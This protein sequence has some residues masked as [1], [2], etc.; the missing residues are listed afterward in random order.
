MV[1]IIKYVGTYRVLAPLDYLTNKVTSNK[2]DTYLLGRY[3]IQAYRWNKNTICLLFPSGNST[4]NIILPQFDEAGIKYTLHI[5]SDKEKIYKVKES[6]IDKIHNI[7][8]FQIKGKG[9]SPFSVKTERKLVK[10]EESKKQ[11]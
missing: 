3:S 6:D 5:D 11:S 2:N 10:Q 4:S 7:V 1:K 9:I 8:H